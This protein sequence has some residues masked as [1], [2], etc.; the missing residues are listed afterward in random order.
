MHRWKPPR[1]RCR[2]LRTSTTDQK[3]PL[4][5]LRAANRQDSTDAPTVAASSI[6]RIKKINFSAPSTCPIDLF[7]P[8]ANGRALKQ[9]HALFRVCLL[10]SLQAAR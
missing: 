2:R 7:G 8:L 1:L 3:R 10:V 9:L 5:D 6:S 4:G